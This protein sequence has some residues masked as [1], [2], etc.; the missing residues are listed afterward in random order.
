MLPLWFK[1]RFKFSSKWI[2]NGINEC[3]VISINEDTNTCKIHVKTPKTEFTEDDWN[4]EH[5]IFGFERGE[6][7]RIKIP[8]HLID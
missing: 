1:P 6:Y 7:S 3:T 4:L 5:T 2:N 8:H